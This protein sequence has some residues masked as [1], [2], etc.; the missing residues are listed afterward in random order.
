MLWAFQIGVV[1]SVLGGVW[2]WVALDRR[3]GRGDALACVALAL[4]TVS[5]S[6]G[7]PLAI[8]V[9]AEILVHRRWRGL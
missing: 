1:G 3:D 6:L 2:A 7:V 4:G 9:G 8:G 5:S